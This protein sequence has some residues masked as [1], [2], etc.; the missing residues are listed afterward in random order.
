MTNGGPGSALSSGHCRFD[1]AHIESQRMNGRG[2]GKHVTLSSWER[3]GGSKLRGSSPRGRAALWEG[4][5]QEP[6]FESITLL[7]MKIST[8]LTRASGF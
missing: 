4:Y 3:E 1:A 7:V 8:T 5:G 2:P 6:I